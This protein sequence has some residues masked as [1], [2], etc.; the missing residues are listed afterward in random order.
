M[1]KVC[2]YVIKGKKVN[3]KLDYCKSFALNLGTEDI[4]V[5]HM[6]TLA[7]QRYI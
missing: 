6:S 3:C 1:S 2:Q 4:G 5:F 7:E